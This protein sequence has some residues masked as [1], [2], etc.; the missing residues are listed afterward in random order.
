MDGTLRN[1]EK[2]QLLNLAPHQYSR[3]H[4]ASHFLWKEKKC[5]LKITNLEYLFSYHNLGEIFTWQIYILLYSQ[6][7]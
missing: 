5:D 4:I 1:F 6:I 7:E 2:F 3:L